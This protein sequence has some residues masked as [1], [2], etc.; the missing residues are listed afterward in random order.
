MPIPEISLVAPWPGGKIARVLTPCEQ[1]VP[2]L[3]AGISV[4]CGLPSGG[5]LADW[6]KQLPEVAAVDFGSLPEPQERN[7]LWVAQQVVNSDTRLRPVM[8]RRVAAHLGEL[9][10]AATPSAALRS[11]ARTP[12]H[13]GLVLTLNYDRL[14][15]RA[16]QDAGR[17]VLPLGV[18]DIPSLLNDDLANRDEV[19]RV[20]HLHGS[21]ND[22]PEDLILDAQGYARRADDQNV[23]L[24]FAALLAF[25]NLCIT[26]SSFEE[27]YL[28]TVL[29]ARRASDAR[30]VIVCDSPV[31]SRIREGQ[32]AITTQAHNVLVCDYPAGEHDVL[33]AFCERLVTCKELP[34][35]GADNIET[36]T[37]EI[38]ELY[39]ERRFVDVQ[40]LSEIGGEDLEVALAFE[41]VEVLDEE[42][43][44][45]E[46]RAVVIGPPVGG[47][48]LLLEHLGRS[49]RAGERGVLVRLRDVRTVIGEASDLV[50]DWIAYGHVVD[51]G[52][53]VPVDAVA[54]GG[55][56][57]HLLLDG[58]DELP[59]E[60]RTQVAEAVVRIAEALPEQ[61]LTL[62]SRPGSA[63]DAFTEPWRKFELLCDQRWRDDLLARV[64]ID[65]AELDARLGGLLP[66]VEPLL[67]V[68]FFMRRVLDLLEAEEVPGDGLDVAL[69]L[70][71]RLQAQDDQLQPLGQA[72]TRWLERIALKM[73]LA[74][75]TSVAIEE[76]RAL[77]EGTELGDPEAVAELLANRALL[78]ESS[79][80]YGFQHRLFGEALVAQYLL[81]QSPA[82]WLDVIAPRVGAFA[83]LREDWIGVADLL[84]PRSEGWRVAVANRDPRAAARATPVDARPEEREGAARFLWER[85]QTLDIWIDRRETRGVRTD[86]EALSGFISIGGLENLM[87]QVRE[88][89]FVGSRFQRGNAVDIVAGARFSDCEALLRRILVDDEDSVVRRIAASG[90]R[91]LNLTNLSA[92]IESRATRAADQSEAS[93]LAMVAIAL[94]PRRERVEVAARMLAAGNTEIRDWYVTEEVRPGDQ[95]RWL[96]ARASQGDWEPWWARDHL[97]DLVRSLTRPTRRQ[98][99]QLGFVAALSQANSAPVIDFVR[100]HR[101]AVVGLIDALDQHLVETY[102]IVDL[103]LAA[104]SL[105]LTKRGATRHVVEDVAWQ[106]HA[107]AVR[108]H[109]PPTEMRPARPAAPQSLEQIMDLEDRERRIA[110]LLATG[111]RLA[112]PAPGASPKTKARLIADLD[113]LWGDQDL[114]QAIQHREGEAT[115]SAWAAAVLRYGP[116]VEWALTEA[117]WVQAALCGW[118]FA[119]QLRWLSSQTTSEL[120][121]TALSESDDTRSLADLADLAA[122]DELD[123]LVETVVGLADDPLPDRLTD[124]L[125]SR[126]ARA[127]RADLLRVLAGHDV[128]TASKAQPSL[129]A[130]GDL[131][132]Q[133]TQL[134]DLQARL[135]A[136]QRIQRREAG[137][138]D[139]VIDR[140]L[141]DPLATMIPIVGARAP[142]DDRPFDSVLTA[143]EEAAERTDP[144]AAVALYTSL[145]EAPPWSGAQF[146]VYRRD[147]VL[148]R[149]AANEGQRAAATMI[150][151]LGL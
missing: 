1:P 137:W 60:L 91:R 109:I 147:D 32:A 18:N 12:N 14:V 113:E 15:E 8:M 98:S 47:K 151:A 23:R 54:D 90:A 92:P 85:A 28:A 41:R 43:L 133:R 120:F 139:A 24:L 33:E 141:F 22:P 10:D 112:R 42:G 107:R 59:R 25:Q 97:D 26:G 73:S 86:G 115:L 5:E 80:R 81:S 146:L 128:V 71:R 20:L 103:L 99:A 127:R 144:M 87:A 119:P 69:S 76:L 2:L 40:Q 65:Q 29:Q 88:S 79:G 101:N 104:G 44:R 46:R 75:R 125:I 121:A 108:A 123:P 63:L 126:L 106:E 56:R 19:L 124:R 6:I 49:P 110:L 129:A 116:A 143:L 102:D 117:R 30:H 4:P 82:E 7:P 31:A 13:P 131:G 57:V 27:Q 35:T 48:S 94:T 38:D 89:L 70:L 39:I 140:S 55:V 21:L 132:A 136:G 64:A 142:D 114:R 145:V 17:E 96:V 78:R 61:R 95:L 150:R 45:A 11:I 148:Q 58:L 105:E 149:Q 51:G 122:D 84:L 93:D 74:G 9:E 53:E 138:L 37:P 72:L 83:V 36:A 52:S 34:A 16:A 67:R 66:A 111:E 118:L 68:P 3:G 50:A 77:A 134:A 100:R 130:A 62:S 135:E